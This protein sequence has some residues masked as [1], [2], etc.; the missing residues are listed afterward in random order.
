MRV[1]RRGKKEEKKRKSF[2]EVTPER[3]FLSCSR[4][5][6]SRVCIKTYV[7]GERE[8]GVSPLCKPERCWSVLVGFYRKLGGKPGSGA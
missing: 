4:S 3:G 1:K 8:R 6:R 5:C 7:G 2:H